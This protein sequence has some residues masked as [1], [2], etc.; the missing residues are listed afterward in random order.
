[1]SV[2]KVLPLRCAEHPDLIHALMYPVP[3]VVVV[4]LLA[5]ALVVGGLG[6]LRRGEVQSAPHRGRRPAGRCWSRR[7]CGGGIDD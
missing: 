6:C 1:M 5:G 7:G 4:A 2:P 3:A